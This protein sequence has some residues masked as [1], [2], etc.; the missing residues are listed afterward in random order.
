[1]NQ[2]DNRKVATSL[3]QEHRQSL[4]DYVLRLVPNNERSHAQDVVQETFLRTL[5]YLNKGKQVDSPKGFLYTTAR[6][7][8]TS[9]FYRGPK[10]TEIALVP[11]IDEYGSSAKACSPENEALMRQKL[12]TFCTAIATLPERYQE[13]FVRRRIWGESC[14]EIGDIMHLSEA[15]VSNYASLGWKLVVEYFDERGIVMDDF[16]D[17]DWR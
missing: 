14:K 6:N 17:R 1:M 3:Y 5:K 9:M 15:V 13:A 10:R 2:A 4:E 16:V 8:I 7:V 11:D 12:D